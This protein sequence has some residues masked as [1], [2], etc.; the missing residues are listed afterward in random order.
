MLRNMRSAGIDLDSS[1]GAGLLQ[2]QA[3]RPSRYGLE[4]HLV[5][6]HRAVEQ[7]RPDVVVVDPMTNL[8]TVGTQVDVRAMLIRMID[9]LKA[10]NITALFTGLAPGGGALDSTETAISSLMDTWVLMTTEEADRRRH[11]WLSVLKSRGMPHSDEVREFRFSDRGVDLLP[12]RSP[13]RGA[14]S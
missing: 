10:R 5:L 4:T 8:L 6:M 3:D 13:E 12:V 11:R 2:F 9:F 14:E 1:V 7:F